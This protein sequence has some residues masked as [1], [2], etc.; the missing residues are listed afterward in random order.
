MTVM[1]ANWLR[2]IDACRGSISAVLLG[3][4]GFTN[5]PNPFAACKAGRLTYCRQAVPACSDRRP[6]PKRVRRDALL[7]TVVK[8]SGSTVQL[9]VSQFVS[10]GDSERL[11]NIAEFRLDPSITGVENKDTPDPMK[12]ELTPENAAAI[13][14]RDR[15][16]PLFPLQS[17][18]GQRH[19]SRYRLC[20]SYRRCT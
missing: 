9:L 3:N 6:Q 20:Y 10:Q 11:D 1:T 18:A 15:I 14:T 4:Q 19:Q 12:I 17:A 13:K 8:R 7:L 5:D 16:L 2:L